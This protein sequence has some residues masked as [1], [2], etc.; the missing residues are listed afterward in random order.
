MVKKANKRANDYE[1]TEPYLPRQ[2]KSPRRLDNSASSLYSFPATS[3]DYYQQIYFEA[4]DLIVNYIKD[5]FDQ[6]GYKIFQN[7]QNVIV[8]VVNSEEYQSLLNQARAG[9]RLARAWFLKIDSVRIV[10]MRACVCECPRPRLLITSGV[11][12]RDINLIR[13]VKQVLQLLYGDCSRYS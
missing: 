10:C 12:W 7:V 3:E 13:L 5:R 8:Q 11:M 2:R 4:I 6:L 9:R 1:V